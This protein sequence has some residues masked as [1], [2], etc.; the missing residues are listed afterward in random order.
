MQELKQNY[1]GKNYYLDDKASTSW[2]KLDKDIFISVNDHQIQ[3][4]SEKSSIVKAMIEK[5]RLQRFYVEHPKMKAS[6]CNG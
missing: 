3:P 4:L 5:P 6:D 1:V 2:Y